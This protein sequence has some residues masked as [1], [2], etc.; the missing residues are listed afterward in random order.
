MKKAESIDWVSR[1][2]NRKVVQTTSEKSI[3]SKLNFTNQR[4]IL[5]QSSSK[6]GIKF[7]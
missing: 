1:Y 2:E 3:V 6:V 4:K 5:I 7:S